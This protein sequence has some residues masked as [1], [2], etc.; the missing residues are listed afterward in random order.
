[1]F[2]ANSGV[3]AMQALTLE[4]VLAPWF[5]IVLSLAGLTVICTVHNRLI[6]VIVSLIVLGILLIPV[7]PDI[8]TFVGRNP[9]LIPTTIVGIPTILVGLTVYVGAVWL[10]AWFSTVSDKINPVV[11][12][13]AGSFIVLLCLVD[14]ALIIIS[15]IESG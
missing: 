14:L 9:E 10:L 13:L 3:T 4:I 5:K 7:F 12:N 1:M 2:H 8:V 11:A 15:L 6:N